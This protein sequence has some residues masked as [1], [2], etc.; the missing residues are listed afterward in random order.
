MTCQK[1]KNM[2]PGGPSISQP[3][4]NLAL[5]QSEGILTVEASYG[6]TFSFAS[7]IHF[8]AHKTE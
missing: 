8:G 7:R 6:I 3:Q 2:I 5:I 4:K 1:M